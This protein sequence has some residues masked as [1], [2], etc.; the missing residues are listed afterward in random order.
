M[1]LPSL[2]FRSVAI[3]STASRRLAVACAK[4]CDDK[5]AADIVVL[6][7]RKL[8]FYADYFVI[9]TTTNERQSRAIAEELYVTM[10]HQG[11]RCLSN[12]QQRGDARWVLEDF[13]DVVVHLMSGEARE[14]YGLEE[15]WA[16]A[17]PVT[18]TRARRA[19]KPAAEG[20]TTQA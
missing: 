17:K 1:R 11:I 3:V 10:K 7:V 13:G 6:D 14:F 19:K 20:E 4:I 8:V 2:S 18:W 16:D 9:A 5:K 15:L 12:G